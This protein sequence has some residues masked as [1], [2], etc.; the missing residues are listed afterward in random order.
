MPLIGNDEKS[1]DVNDNKEENMKISDAILSYIKSDGPSVIEQFKS[2][3][4]ESFKIEDM[5]TFFDTFG[6]KQKYVILQLQ[7][8]ALRG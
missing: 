3:L 1:W 8:C 7:K 2:G 4:L 5:D 6:K